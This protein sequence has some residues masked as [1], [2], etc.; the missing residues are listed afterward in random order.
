MI[1]EPQGNNMFMQGVGGGL[2]AI[3]AALGAKKKQRQ[4]QMMA[5]QLFEK[6]RNMVD[7]MRDGGMDASE[8]AQIMATMYGK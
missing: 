6:K 2:N 4:D 3:I 1:Q 5:D 7:D 8:V